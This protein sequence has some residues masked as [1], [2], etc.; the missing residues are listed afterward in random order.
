MY[1]TNQSRVCRACDSKDI[2]TILN[3]GEMPP[4]DKY[5]ELEELVPKTLISSNIDIC[6]EC[7]HIQMS[8]SADPKYIY[9]NYLSRPASTNPSLKKQYME[10]CSDISDL[11][12]GGSV[13][14]VGSND[15]LFLELFKNIGVNAIG[16]EPA[17]NLIEFAKKRGVE[18]IN[19]YV[20][21]ENVNLAVNKI[22]N[23]SVVLA[24]H[25]FSNVENIQEWA[26]AISG[27]LE[28]NG[29]LVLQTFYQK[30]VLENYLLENYNHEHL[31]YVFVEPISNFFKKY[32]LNLNKCRYISAK[33]G[34]IRLFFKKTKNNQIL[35]DESIRILSEEKLFL[36]NLDTNFEKTF[37]YIKN[38]AKQIKEIINKNSDKKVAAYGTS[39]GA[40][41]FTYQFNLMERIETFFDDDELRQ[42][43]YSPGIG[44]PVIAGKSSELNKYEYCLIFAPLYFK[45][46][47]KNNLNFLHNNGKFI[48]IRPKVEI[49]SIDN[50]DSYI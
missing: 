1:S 40:T 10:Y 48:L 5:S 23:P 22:G 43:R 12:E 31:S 28:E 25:C 24:N 50:L 34:S 13:L 3:L 35:D 33:G 9:G 2:R 8:G 45:A 4:G 41:V 39:I 16:I 7:G 19:G 18:T 30:S 42:G 37:K 32:G 49:I 38:T 15:G 29:Y 27:G 6:K 21:K 46:I 17:T 26:S 14:E 47:I 20:S 36:S 11:A 44:A